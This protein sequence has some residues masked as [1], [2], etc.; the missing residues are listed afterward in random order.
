MQVRMANWLV[1][2]VLGN[3][4]PKEGFTSFRVGVGK[5]GIGDRYHVS[6]PLEI[7]LKVGD[8]VDFFQA[9]PEFQGANNPFKEPATEGKMGHDNYISM[10]LYRTTGKEEPLIDL[11]AD[12]MKLLTEIKNY[13]RHRGE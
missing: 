9:T 13:S 11:R 12:D 3:T 7:F 4:E 1:T 2:R 10:R 8:R 6:L 5:E